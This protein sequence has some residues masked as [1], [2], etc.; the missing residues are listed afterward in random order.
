MLVEV[1]RCVD[2]WELL[3]GGSNS[4]AL[5]TS[6]ARSLSECIDGLVKFGDDSGVLCA[7]LLE[8]LLESFEL[9]LE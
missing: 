4:C 8:I 1:I 2:C 5:D 6:R 3:D 9:M 7:E